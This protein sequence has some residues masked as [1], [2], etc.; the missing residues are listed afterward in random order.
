MA[1]DALEQA[2]RRGLLDPRPCVTEALHIDVDAGLEA[3]R[4]V[5]EAAGPRD[6]AAVL[7]YRELASACEQARTA[8][9]FVYRRLRT[10]LVDRQAGAELARRLE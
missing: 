8:D 6:L 2:V 10:G 9:D 3:A 7:R 1:F 5:A 4:R